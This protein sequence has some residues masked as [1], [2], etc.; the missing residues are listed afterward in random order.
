V[1][2]PTGSPLPPGRDA[3][4]RLTAIVGRLQNAGD[5]ANWS[6][7][8]QPGGAGAASTRSRIEALVGERRADVLGLVI[9]AVVSGINEAAF[10]IVVA[11]VAVAISATHRP[12]TVSFHL[13][14]ISAHPT[15]A[16]LF[17]LA[18]TLGALRFALQVPISLLSARISANVQARLRR[19]LF[20]AYSDAS[21]SMQSRE[22][23]GHIQE[24]VTSQVLQATSGAVQASQLIVA[25]IS[26]LVLMAFALVLSAAAAAVIL[27]AA[28]VLFVVLRPLRALGVRRARSL[29]QAQMAF[30]SGVGEASRLAEETKVFGVAVPQRQRIEGLIS[31]AEAL[32]YRTQMVGRL[33]PGIYQSLNLILLVGVLLGL[34]LEGSGHAGSL[35][36]V[37]LLV[38]RAGGNGQQIQSSYQGLRQSLPFIERLQDTAQRF[39]RSRDCY[40]TTPLPVVHTLGLENVSFAYRAA[41]PVLRNVSFQVQAGEA[42]GIIGPSGGGK[43]TLAS[44][45]LRLRVPEAGRY[46]GRYLVNGIPAQDF[47][48]ED[49]SRRF[50]YVAQEPRLIHATVAENIRYLR[51]IDD[52]DVQRAARLAR[53]HDD[54]LSW[55][56]GYDTIVGPRA[57]AVSGGQQQRICIARALAA[58]PAVLVLDEPTSSLDPL[59]ESIIK[60]SLTALKAELTIFLVAHHVS[61][62]AICDRVMVVVDGRLVAFQEPDGLQ[63]DNAYYRSASLLAAGP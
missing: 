28:I 41:Q 39:Q 7:H 56:D 42:I 55:P 48:A 58:R 18:F 3:P 29:S 35:S 49:W 17:V 53:I 6:A 57:D 24:I 45:L 60:E 12:H 25:A 44:L 51:A 50:A 20:S 63:A 31:A 38:V 52:D 47:L 36:A 34:Y 9:A 30:A 15:I 59:S 11:R 27:V 4:S 10:L 13:G 16:V 21:W 40:G 46:L 54:I 32:F 14:P 61:T 22:R 23:E 19:E 43:S 33:V 1:R 37:V 62:L 26:F 5:S 8:S 2:E